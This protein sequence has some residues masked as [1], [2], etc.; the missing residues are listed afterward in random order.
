MN[1]RTLDRIN[2]DEIRRRV[3]RQWYWRI[4][5]GIIILGV[6]M[7]IGS[8]A[9]PLALVGGAAG[10]IAFVVLVAPIFGGYP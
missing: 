1:P 8:I 7:G 2:E 9:P 5:M 4:P 6:C 10:V 3:R